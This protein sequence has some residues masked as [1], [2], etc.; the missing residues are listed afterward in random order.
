MKNAQVLKSMGSVPSA[1]ELLKINEYTRRE[2]EASELYVFSVVLCDNDVD[3]DF[4]RFTV[5]ALFEMEKLFVGKTGICD[6]TPKAENQRARIF[7]CCVEAP[8]GR[9]TVTGDDYFRL[10]AKAY[11]PR[12][13]DNEGLIMS[14]ESGI[15][16]EVSVGL[17]A[18]KSTCS[19]C[20]EERGRCSH[21]GG[22]TY[23]ST[24]CFYELSQVSDAYEW[25][26]V[27][28]PAQ[29]EA[30]VI[31]SYILSNGKD[32]ENMKNIIKTLSLGEGITLKSEE[33]K[34]LANYIERLEKR[35][36]A[37]EDYREELCGEFKRLSAVS[38]PE[39]SE[40]TIDKMAD[41]LEI[42]Q[43]KEFCKV[44]TKKAQETFGTGV[45]QTKKKPAD[46]QQDLKNYSI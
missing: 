41:S 29:R 40:K 20:A 11:M 16:K 32:K 34:A 10:V 1:Q 9:K 14:I 19:V 43:L 4:E 6:H 28:V 23:G 18:N 5:E 35:A 24:L 13:A 27:A 3:R 44:F 36:M 33:C 39:I 2:F 38:M 37:A 7:E 15:T 21:R 45:V 25:S 30:G 26:F 12:T 17:S 42:S 31:K 46:T 22:E 8:A